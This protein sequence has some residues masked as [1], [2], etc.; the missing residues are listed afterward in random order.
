MLLF[1][2]QLSRK[3]HTL[4]IEHMKNSSFIHFLLDSIMLWVLVLKEKGNVRN[5]YSKIKISCLCWA[6]NKII[7]FLGY[8]LDYKVG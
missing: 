4:N 7:I 2:Y 3:R 8:E 6:F 5:L 1:L